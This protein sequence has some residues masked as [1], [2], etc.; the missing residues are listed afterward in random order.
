MGSK[1]IIGTEHELGLDV[2]TVR[3]EESLVRA[4]GTLV[5]EDG[6]PQIE[7]SDNTGLVSNKGRR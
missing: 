2:D 3:I 7:L 5:S 1:Y 4:L 6:C